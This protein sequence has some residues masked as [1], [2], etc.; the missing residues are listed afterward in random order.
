LFCARCRSTWNTPHQRNTTQHQT[1][2]KPKPSD[3]TPPRGQKSL[4]SFFGS[5]RSSKTGE[6]IP[7][8]KVQSGIRAAFRKG[9]VGF[10]IL[11]CGCSLGFVGDC[12]WW[13]YS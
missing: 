9:E 5:A 10:W 8:G 3:P 7:S 2:V 1:M 6:V 4:T 12:D 13:P 11:L